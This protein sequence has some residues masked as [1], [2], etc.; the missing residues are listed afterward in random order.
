VSSVQRFVVDATDQANV[1]KVID[2]LR[3]NSISIYRMQ[4][5]RA[6]LEQVFMSIVGAANSTNS[7]SPNSFK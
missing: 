7:T 1:D 5:Y 3:E 6:S 4:R 2:R